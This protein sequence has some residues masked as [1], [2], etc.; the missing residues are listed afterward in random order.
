MKTKW[1]LKTWPGIFQ[2]PAVCG[3]EKESYVRKPSVVL[4]TFLCICK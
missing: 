1:Y 4:D 3:V 2:F